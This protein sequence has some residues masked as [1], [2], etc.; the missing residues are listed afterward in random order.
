MYWFHCPQRILADFPELIADHQIGVVRET[1]THFRCT[2]GE[3]AYEIDV[4][5]SE[6]YANISVSAT[7]APKRKP[8][9]IREA[10][11]RDLIS[12]AN[13]LVSHGI[14]P[15]MPRIDDELAFIESKFTDRELIGMVSKAR[16]HHEIVKNMIR[17]Q[18]FEE[19]SAHKKK[20]DEIRDRIAL[21]CIEKEKG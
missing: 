21:I 7:S 2:V 1:D 10:S 4:I 5:R 19:A 14:E 16:H 18:N 13:R 3:S 12:L 20:R 9:D 6:Y 11:D 17:A 8:Q 15:I